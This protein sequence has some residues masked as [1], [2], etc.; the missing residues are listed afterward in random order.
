MVNNQL[1]FRIDPNQANADW[2][3]VENKELVGEP[4]A[5]SEGQTAEIKLIASSNTGGD[6]ESVTFYIPIAYDASR[7]PIITQVDELKAAAGEQLYKDFHD[8]IVD[9]ANDSYLKLVIDRI[10]PAAPWLEI[11]SANPTALEGRVPQE[12][13]GAQYEISLHANSRVGGDSKLVQIALKIAIDER[14]TPHFKE[15]HPQLPLAYSGQ[16]FSYDFVANRDVS[17]EYED[18]PL[19]KVRDGW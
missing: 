18:V 13:I 5:G 11:S 10:E 2:L 4:P 14:L 7:K 8:S 17:P 6:S 19:H 12:V 1:S 9:P 16:T 3:K 15:P